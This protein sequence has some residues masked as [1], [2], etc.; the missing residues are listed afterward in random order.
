NLQQLMNLLFGKVEDELP[1]IGLHLLL[2]DLDTNP[3]A[4]AVDL[5]V[6]A[7]LGRV[8][9]TVP[10]SL[11]RLPDQARRNVFAAQ[12]GNALEHEQVRKSVLRQ[13]GNQLLA[14]PAPQLAIFDL[15]EP[16]NVLAAIGPARLAV[17]DICGSVRVVPPH[18][19]IIT[20]R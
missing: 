18:T 4:F 16:A 1:G 10:Q 14:L 17:Q 12:A 3:P 11:K 20:P 8:L 15:Q 6:F 19:P 7:R 5:D 2:A 13:F 9:Q